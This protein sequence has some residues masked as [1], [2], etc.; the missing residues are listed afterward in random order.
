M[1]SIRCAM[2]AA[3]PAG[4]SRERLSAARS[5]GSLARRSRACWAE[6]SGLRLWCRTTTDM[7]D[8]CLA[9]PSRGCGSLGG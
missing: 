3:A 6:R 2:F 1:C 8:D 7:L 4:S 9:A 5:A